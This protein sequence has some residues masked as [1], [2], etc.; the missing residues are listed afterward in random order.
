MGTRIGM[1]Q[2][3][4]AGGRGGTW[5]ML[6]D[7]STGL[8]QPDYNMGALPWA[9]HRLCK[10]LC[11]SFQCKWSS[12]ICRRSTMSYWTASLKHRA[13]NAWQQIPGKYG[14]AG[15]RLLYHGSHAMRDVQNVSSVACV[16]SIPCC[17][18]L[19]YCAAAL[20]VRR[21]SAASSTKQHPPAA[22]M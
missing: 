17:A 5:M 3:V 7:H 18:N 16:H 12:V 8:Q 6:I 2:R 4:L 1:Q 15:C 21:A 19:S 13:A 11:S 22:I 20:Q 10:Q 9:W 14:A